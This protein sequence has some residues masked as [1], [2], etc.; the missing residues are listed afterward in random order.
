[1]LGVEMTGEGATA[2]MVAA[3]PPPPWAALDLGDAMMASSS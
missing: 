2:E 3:A 1:M